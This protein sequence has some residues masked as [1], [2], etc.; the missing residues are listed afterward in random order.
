MYLKASINIKKLAIT[1]VAVG[2]RS[3]APVAHLNPCARS[4]TKSALMRIKAKLWR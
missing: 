3:C 4:H 1:Q 2:S